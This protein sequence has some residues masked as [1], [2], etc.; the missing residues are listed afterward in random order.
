MAPVPVC[1]GHVPFRCSSAL[2]VRPSSH[3]TMLSPGLTR[4]SSHL[5]KF[6]V[7]S[8][9]PDV[10]PGPVP[11]VQHSAP[12]RCV[13]QSLLRLASPAS[14]TSPAAPAQLQ[15]CPADTGA[16]VQQGLGAGG[17][18][19]SSWL[20]AET[21]LSV[22]HLWSMLMVGQEGWSPHTR[23]GKPG[24]NNS[25]PSDPAALPDS[26]GAEAFSLDGAEII[27]RIHMSLGHWWQ[28]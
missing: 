4:A 25:G 10:R 7:S 17:S 12:R 22:S 3:F 16:A 11:A 27:L 18:C 23:I 19:S 20:P 5:E 26:P 8:V 9:S 14:S 2:Q 24:Q 28:T 1:R 13:S 6:L 15:Q 21:L